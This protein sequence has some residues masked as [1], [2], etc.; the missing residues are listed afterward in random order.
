MTTYLSSEH[1]TTEEKNTPEYKKFKE[2]AMNSNKLHRIR[3]AAEEDAADE[4]RNHVDKVVKNKKATDPKH[5]QHLS[6]IHI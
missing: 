5:T 6:I 4:F 1:L 2:Q 3:K